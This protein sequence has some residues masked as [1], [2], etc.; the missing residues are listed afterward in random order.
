MSYYNRDEAVSQAVQMVEKAISS[1][2]LDFENFSKYGD[3]TEGGKDAAAFI[4]SLISELTTHL[5]KL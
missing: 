3:K 4:G 5:Q 2:A 1:G